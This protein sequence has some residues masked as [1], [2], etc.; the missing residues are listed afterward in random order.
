[1]TRARL[2]SAVTLPAEYRSLTF[3]RTVVERA[4][5]SLGW[6]DDASARIV[7]ASAEAVCNAIE[8][9]SESGADVELE[10]WA[11]DATAWVQVTDHGRGDSTV[12]MVLPSSPPDAQASRGRGLVIMSRLSEDL[13]IHDNA[14]GGTT[15]LLRFSADGNADAPAAEVA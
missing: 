1:M 12:P 11:E 7:L 2:V 5:V 15:V 14:E 6:D 3:A 10:L 4:L 13:D 8:H 9:G